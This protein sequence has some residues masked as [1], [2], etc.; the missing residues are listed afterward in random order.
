MRP[1]QQT[2]TQ[3]DELAEFEKLHRRCS[4]CNYNSLNLDAERKDHPDSTEN[5]ISR[6]LR[7]SRER[8]RTVYEIG[9]GGRNLNLRTLRVN[10]D[11]RV[12]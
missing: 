9:F 6:G 5:C 10:L 11:D 8:D 12:S 3:D 4:M 1:N 2:P 7:L